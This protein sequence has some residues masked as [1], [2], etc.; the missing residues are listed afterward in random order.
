MGITIS[1]PKLPPRFTPESRLEDLMLAYGKSPE[2]HAELCREFLN[3]D[4]ITLGT[5]APGSMLEEGNHRL[6]TDTKFT[7]RL[8]EYKGEPVVAIY[9]SMKRLTDVIPEEYYRGTGY[10]GLK[11]K[12][13]LESVMSSGRRDKFALNPGH[14]VVKTLSADEVQALLDGT[15]LQTA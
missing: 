2:T 6:E 4:I 11:C 7:F 14:M 13:L 9:S 3:S 12:T 8:L 15:I 1:K 5:P 10:I